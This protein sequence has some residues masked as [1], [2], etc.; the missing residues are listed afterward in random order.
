MKEIMANKDEVTQASAKTESTRKT[1]L[2]EM[3]ETM[4]NRAVPVPEENKE[5]EVVER[6]EESVKANLGEVKETT[7]REEVKEKAV[8]NGSTNELKRIE[9]DEKMRGLKEMLETRI[10][11]AQGDTLELKKKEEPVSEKLPAYQLQ[12]EIPEPDSQEAYNANCSPPEAHRQSEEQTG[13]AQQSAEE[14]IPPADVP[15]EVQTSPED[16]LPELPADYQEQ[17]ELVEERAKEQTES[18]QPI[19]QTNYQTQENDSY[20]DSRGYEKS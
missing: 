4:A 6:S 8:E 5:T 12:P 15:T 7:A 19:E 18:V 1:Y 2:D 3:R 20:E 17:N 13:A 10:K 11:F 9:E 16:R 14:L